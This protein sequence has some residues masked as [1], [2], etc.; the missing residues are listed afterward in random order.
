M[1]DQTDVVLFGKLPH[2]PSPFVLL[3]RYRWWV[4]LDDLGPLCGYLL[5]VKD[6]KDRRQ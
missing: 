2:L 6:H 5:D 3:T 1:P 4:L